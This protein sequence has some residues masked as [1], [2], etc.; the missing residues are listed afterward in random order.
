MLSIYE[1]FQKKLMK[2][3]NTNNSSPDVHFLR[4]VNES[5]KYQ[6]L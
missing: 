2:V 3:K 1:C 6:E 4:H 5:G